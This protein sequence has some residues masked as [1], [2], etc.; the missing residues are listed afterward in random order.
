MSKRIFISGRPGVGKTTVFFKVI[1]EVKRH[2]LSVGGFVCPEIRVGGRRI[3]FDIIDIRTGRRG[4]LARLCSMGIH[5]VRPELRVG[6]YCI[7]P[8]EAE[9]VGVKAVENALSECD[10]VAIDEIGP[11]ELKV[12][13]LREVMIKALTSNKIIF[14]VVHRGI[15]SKYSILYKAKLLWINESNRGH[16]HE[17][18]INLI[19]GSS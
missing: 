2:G 18:I 8:S 4:R 9:D 12:P 14:A 16:V 3:G 13:K 7:I 15:A 10:I 1:D 19:I 17:D 11:M 5:N 6:R